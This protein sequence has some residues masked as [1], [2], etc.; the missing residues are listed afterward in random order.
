MLRERLTRMAE[1][2]RER[3]RRV[4]AHRGSLPRKPGAEPV[5]QAWRAEHFNG[6]MRYR[7]DESHPA[8]R[9]VLEQAGTLEP[10][11]RAMLRV[12]QE[13]IPVQRIWLD[14]TEARETPRTGFA[15]EP[16]AEV[17]AILKVMYRNLV[18]RKG[19]APELARA[20][21]RSAEPFNNYPQLVD[22]LPD[23]PGEA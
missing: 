2:T 19:M 10:Q 7:I 20:R 23:L 15:G 9:E 18:T 22:T 3:A 21:L 12:I 6:G 5:A 1:D 8:V 14:T 16:P 13:T 11:L 4:F 17:T